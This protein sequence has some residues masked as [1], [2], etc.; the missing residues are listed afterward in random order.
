MQ[1]QSSSQNPTRNSQYQTLIALHSLSFQRQ[2]KRGDR[3]MR[4]GFGVERVV[5]AASQIIDKKFR[6]HR[7]ARIFRGRAELPPQNRMRMA[8][9]QRGLRFDAETRHFHASLHALCTDWSNA[10]I[11]RRCS[12]NRQVRPH[13]SKK[14]QNID[15]F[16]RF[17]GSDEFV[18]MSINKLTK[19][20]V[21]QN[22]QA[23]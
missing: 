19:N 1:L 6:D 13:L 9:S 23:F 11:T 17:G 15:M 5:V 12:L 14:S 22:I 2:S 3:A 21:L 10:C 7:V 8:R 16:K 4:P 18:N 20:L